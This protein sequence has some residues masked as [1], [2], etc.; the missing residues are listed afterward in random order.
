ML[1]NMRRLL[2]AYGISSVFA[3][4]NAQSPTPYPY[5]P[6]NYL[7]ATSDPSILTLFPMSGSAIKLSLPFALGYVA[8]SPDGKSL[9]AA[10]GLGRGLWK[11][12]F[13]PTHATSVPGSLEFGILSM[14][15]S[16][17]ED[18]IVISGFRRHNDR[19]DFGIFELTLP[20][21]NARQVLRSPDLKPGSAWADLSISPNG[22][23][24][25]AIHKHQLEL[26]DII[27]GATQPI[28]SDF[29]AGAWAPNGRWIAVLAGKKSQ[30]F[31]IDPAN[32]SHRLSL[33]RV[34]G[35]VLWSP[36][37][38]YLLLTREQLF[39]GFYLYSLETLEIATGKRSLVRSSR[40]NIE[41]GAIG[42]V[43]NGITL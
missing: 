18:R 5:S 24:A 4:M 25:V 37:S 16:A 10:T 19:T 7:H 17:H 21:G 42:W 39:C 43:D 12:K 26:I 35:G 1:K 32:L 22:E 33:G 31:L 28:G 40:C 13:N 14:A 23:R 20:D 3:F 15:V 2:L 30:L 6:A 27:K 36:D 8:F 41:G 38:R 9:Y 11:I 34:D 29:W